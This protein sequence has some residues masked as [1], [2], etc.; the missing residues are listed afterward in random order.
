MT[1]SQFSVWALWV[2]EFD[3]D[4]L[5]EAFVPR[6]ALPESVSSPGSSHRADVDCERRRLSTCRSCS[7]CL[8]GLRWPRSA[9][10]AK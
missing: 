7:A 4:E 6:L 1:L 10:G 2:F 8:S 3:T 9:R 5:K